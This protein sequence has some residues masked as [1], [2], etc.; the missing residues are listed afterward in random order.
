MAKL[1]ETKEKI[2]FFKFWLGTVVVTF[3]SISGWLI[4]H[5]AKIEFMLIVFSVFLLF[6]LNIIT[7]FLS[8]IIW[9]E[10]KKL[11]DM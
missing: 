6:I 2:G 8:V 3:L 11:K 4:T 9:R 1:D 7:L 5:I 10:I